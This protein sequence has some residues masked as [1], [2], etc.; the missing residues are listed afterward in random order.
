MATRPVVKVEGA[1][2]LRA[3]LRRAGDDLGDLKTAN[4]AAAALVA[5]AAS[6]DVPRRSGL[7]AGTVRPGATQSA[8]IVRAGS[9]RVP[10]AA[11]IHYGWAARHIEPHPF[12]W[13][14]ATRT[15]MQ[16]LE[17]Y[18]ARIRELV[19]RVERQAHP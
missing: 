8:A 5:R 3:A 17:I 6:L 16:W 11:V 2:Q 15:E 4:L 13:D 19:D 10:Y 18:R 1:R 9:S 7:L 14:P 12:L